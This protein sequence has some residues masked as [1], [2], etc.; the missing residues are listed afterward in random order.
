VK[1]LKNNA[2]LFATVLRKGALFRLVGITEPV[3]LFSCPR[4]QMPVMIIVIS[5][6]SYKGDMIYLLTAIGLKPGRSSTV[7]IYTQTIHRTIKN[8]Y[9]I[10]QHNNFGR[11]RAVLYCGSTVKEHCA[12]SRTVSESIP[13]GV[14]GD[15][16]CSYRQ[17][18]VPW[19][20]LS[21]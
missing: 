13:G 15:F 1:I 7:H 2:V 16:F 11:V 19:G 5:Q 3:S 20:R 14:T 8:K 9:N 10:E 21:L 4:R 6:T 18:D 12:T 17:K